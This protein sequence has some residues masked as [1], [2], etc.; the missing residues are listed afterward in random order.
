MNNFDGIEEVELNGGVRAA[1]N[2]AIQG[3]IYV[4]GWLMEAWGYTEDCPG[5]VAKTVGLIVAKAR[6]AACRKR[7][8]E[9]HAIGNRT[10]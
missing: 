6:S 10:D 2:E 8:Q 7:M 1:R 5:C 9:A 3:V 4:K